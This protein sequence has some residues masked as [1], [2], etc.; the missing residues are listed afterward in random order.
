MIVLVLTLCAFAVATA[1]F[2]LVGVL[3]EVAADLAV[4]LPTAGALV[5]VYMVV[6]AVGGPVLTVLT[7]RVPRGWLLAGVMALALAA[8]LLSA[9]AGSYAVLLGARVGSALAQALFMA[10]AS[11]IAMAAVPPA[12]Q[13]AAV[14]KVFGGFAVATVVG[15]PIGTLIGQSFGW[16]AA[17]LFVAGL[18][19][20]GLAGVVAVVRRVHGVGAVTSPSLAAT[21]AVLARRRVVLGLLVTLLTFT[22]FTAVFTY[23]APMLSDVTRLSPRWVSIALLVYGAGTLLGNALAGRVPAAAIGRI[24]PVPVAL[25]GLLLLLQGVAL[26]AAVPA[27]VNLFVLGAVGLAFAPLVQTY[28]MSQAGP[29]AG[30]LAASVNISAAGIA[31]ALGALLGGGVIE[32]GLGLDRIGPAAAV[33]AFIALAVAAAIRAGAPRPTRGLPVRPRRRTAISR[34]CV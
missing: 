18:A 9:V 25:L 16:H 22:A 1:E 10:V 27:V 13:T 14:A 23:V 21:L 12:K 32:S 31:G 29:A 2:V 20:A 6:V 15:L 11:Q 5:T 19:A 7:G 30:G 24:L 34:P 17:F 4:S 3:G 26:H 33:P 28:L 8:A